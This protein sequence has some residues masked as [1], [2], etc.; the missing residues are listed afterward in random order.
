MKRLF[1]YMALTSVLTGLLV[2]TIGGN[3]CGF[4]Q[5]RKL[6]KVDDP[7]LGPQPTYID[8]FTPGIEFPVAGI[9]L[10]GSFLL[11]HFLIQKLRHRRK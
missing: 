5:N 3:H 9:A 8:K 4:T 7:I 2:W 11:T 10:S 6:V 1:L